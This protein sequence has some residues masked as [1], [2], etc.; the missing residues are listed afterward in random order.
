MSIRL[1]DGCLG[2]VPQGWSIVILLLLGFLVGIGTSVLIFYLKLKKKTRYEVEYRE[3]FGSGQPADV[4]VLLQSAAVNPFPKVPVITTAEASEGPLG[5]GVRTSAVFVR[6]VDGVSSSSMQGFKVTD[7]P[8]ATK[9]GDGTALPSIMIP[10]AA[11]AATSA[12]WEGIEAPLGESLTLS[13]SPAVSI[14]ARTHS[15]MLSRQPSCTKTVVLDAAQEVLDV[16]GIKEQSQQ[17]DVYRNPFD[18]LPSL[19]LSKE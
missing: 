16:E 13:Q 9:E 5:G 19:S 11:A 2:G 15:G 12:P 8:T 3:R 14:E 4:H 10:V 7:N 6:T 18:D 17:E 1:Q